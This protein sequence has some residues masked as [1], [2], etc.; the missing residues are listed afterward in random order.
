MDIVS[1]IGIALLIIAAGAGVVGYFRAN[2]SKATIELYKDD[3]EALRSRVDTLEKQG[4]LD[5]AQIKALG[6]AN[7]F[8]GQVV[9]Q[10]EAIAAVR[11]KVDELANDKM[12]KLQKT[13][14]RI[15]VKVGV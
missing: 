6:D 14:D 4:A 13:V 9:T 11:A 1:L 2:L 7:R 15:A 3:N 5:R 8:L 10:A 12:V